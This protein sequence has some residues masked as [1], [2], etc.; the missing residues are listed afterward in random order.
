MV[1]VEGRIRDRF[2]SVCISVIAEAINNVNNIKMW[3]YDNMN[4][5][6]KGI[7][8]LPTKD[9]M[10]EYALKNCGDNLP[11]VVHEDGE[12]E[13]FKNGEWINGRTYIELYKNK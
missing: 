2:A 8:K 9:E 10:R 13:V 6:A 7:R 5:G 1:G 12:V 4:K 3:R 11:V